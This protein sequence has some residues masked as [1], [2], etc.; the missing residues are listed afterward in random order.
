[1]SNSSLAVRI[2][3]EIERT[4]AFGGISGAYAVVGTPT[5]HAAIQLIFQNQTDA[6]MTFSWDG[7]NAAFTLAA[8]TSFVDDIQS[9]RGRGEAEMCAANT[10]FWVKQVSAPSVGS[11]YISVFYGAN[12]N[13]L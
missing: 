6:P 12:F 11:V 13:N 2:L 5:A 8:Y 3:P 9:N 7:T 10:Q 1:M 4:L